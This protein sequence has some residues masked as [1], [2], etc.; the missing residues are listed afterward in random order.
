MLI[1]NE[2]QDGFGL[3]IGD[4]SIKLLR[5]KAK[6]TF[7]SKRKFIVKNFAEGK[8]P[9]GAILKGEIL[10]KN[11]VENALKSVLEAAGKMPSRAAFVSL[12]ETKTF[13]KLL[14][15][16]VKNKKEIPQKIQE[17]LP[18]IL[19]LSPEEVYF[20]WQIIETEDFGIPNTP[21]SVGN[22]FP[23]IKSLFKKSQEVK[24]YT[25]FIAAAPKT[26][27]DNFFEILNNVGIIPIA[28]E[29]EAVALSRA[30]LPA[31]NKNRVIIDMGATQT[32]LFITSKSAPTVSI[33]LPISGNQLT[34]IMAEKLKI[35]VED[36]DK[37]KKICGLDPKKCDNKLL[38]IVD[39]FIKDVCKKI[40]SAI[41]TYQ[42]LLVDK[43]QL[44][45]ILSG[46]C[47]NLLKL[48]SILSKNLKI[49]TR[50]GAP[51]EIWSIE[52]TDEKFNA[53]L[54]SYSTAIGLAI[55]AILY[56]FPSDH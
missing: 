45:I 43:N 22:L 21:K 42:N 19:P 16:A 29:S 37:L 51:N 1:L 31:S 33:S 8:I 49:K 34:E 9:N 39:S 25:I 40:S 32:S 20:D 54:L 26:T 24:K 47:A 46:G 7:L 18:A 53:S 23:R 44:P 36:A 50:K 14:E 10:D 12:P 5:L 52:S 56:P 27:V 30:L 2:I 35:S 15:I 41:K 3:D 38:P 28:F 4:K 13:L 55:R 11:A 6:R 48:D 17:L